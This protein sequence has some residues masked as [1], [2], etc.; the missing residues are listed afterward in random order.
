M[1]KI[2]V[3]SFCVLAGAAP[4]RVGEVFEAPKSIAKKLIDMGVAR[5]ADLK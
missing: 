2:Q 3:I 5:K 4:L 1:I